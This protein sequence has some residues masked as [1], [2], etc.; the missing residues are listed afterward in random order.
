MLKLIVNNGKTYCV[1]GDNTSVET[2]IVRHFKNTFHLSPANLKTALNGVPLDVN[3]SIHYEMAF[4]YG[5]ADIVIFHIDGS[6]TVIEVK[7]G[8]KGYNHV[9]SGIGQAG[10]YA[11]QL[12]HLSNVRRCLLWTSTSNKSLDIQI[13]KTCN[14]ANVI[15]ALFP[16]LRKMNQEQ[17]TDLYFSSNKE[18]KDLANALF[19]FLAD[20]ADILEDEE[21]S[22][23]EK[24]DF[25]EDV[26]PLLNK[27]R[28]LGVG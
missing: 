19:F 8:S 6:A 28:E 15:P 26:T 21:Y 18:P 12:I 3:D 23:Q 9:V 27:M 4:K 24:I 17:H 10:L 16:S 11:S 2:D 1:S 20:I 14:E 7:D 13:T 25:I 5:R 22:E